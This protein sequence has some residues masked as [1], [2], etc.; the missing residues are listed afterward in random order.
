MI[1][2]ATADNHLEFWT[3]TSA[4]NGLVE[5]M[6]IT[7]N[8]NLLIGKTS[9][10]NPAYMLDVVGSIRS[11]Q[12]VVNTT[13]ADFVFTP[14]YRLKSLSKVKKY[15]DENHHLPGIASAKE[16]RKNGLNVGDN[17][18]KLLQKVEELTL[19]MIEKDKKL[20]RQEERIKR[21]ERLCRDLATH[22]INKK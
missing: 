14:A 11:N 7:N 8:G 4:N 10:T 18:V 22:K 6:R 20:N 9:Q 21:L 15:I 12:V 16:M 5:R 3:N 1:E 17:E 2:A 13:G 19:Y